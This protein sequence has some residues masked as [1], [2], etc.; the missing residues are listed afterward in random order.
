MLFW[1]G[2]HFP[3]QPDPLSG[4]PNL[5]L[6]PHGLSGRLLLPSRCWVK[7]PLQDKDVGILSDVLAVVLILE[8]VRLP[9]PLGSNQICRARICYN[10]RR[11][12]LPLLRQNF[13]RPLFRV[14]SKPERPSEKSFPTTSRNIISHNS[15]GVGRPMASSFTLS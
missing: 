2:V 8:C 10:S 15:R 5:N 12:P 11:A 6:P 7:L 4:G 3:S 14:V 9:R 13:I 1:K